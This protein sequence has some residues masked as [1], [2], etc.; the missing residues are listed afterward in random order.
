MSDQPKSAGHAR[1]SAVPLDKKRT[2]IIL[3]I[4]PVFND[5]AWEI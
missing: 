1:F 5:H 2:N 3:L 4:D